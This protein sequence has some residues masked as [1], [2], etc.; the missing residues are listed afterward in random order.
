VD[1]IIG[2]SFVLATVMTKAWSAFTAPSLTRNVTLCVPTCAFV[3]VP[4]NIRVVV[5][6]VNHEGSTGAEYVNVLPASA[7]VATIV[8]EYAASSF[9]V[10]TAVDVMIGLSFTGVTVTLKE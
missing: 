3:G 9:T 1:V 7:S 6:K 10:R 5:L 8:Y 4:D 2:A